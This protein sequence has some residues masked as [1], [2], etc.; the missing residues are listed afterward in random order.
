MD[1]NGQR[2]LDDYF[3][4]LLNRT[5]VDTVYLN[6]SKWLEQ[7]KKKKEFRTFL[8]IKKKTKSSKLT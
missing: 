3:D 4:A 8:K 1:K 2:M 7:K 5:I 6:H